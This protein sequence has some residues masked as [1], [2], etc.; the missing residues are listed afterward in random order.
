MFNID[1]ETRCIQEA[2][3]V[4]SASGIVITEKQH[5]RRDF[6]MIFCS[7]INL[8]HARVFLLVDET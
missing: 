4:P 1:E 7:T 3:L 8:G 2:S 6:L 5:W